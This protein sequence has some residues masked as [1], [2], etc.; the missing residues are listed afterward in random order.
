ME[1]KV[2][3]VLN[4]ELLSDIFR[5]IFEKIGY[6]SKTV[7]TP[8][9]AIDEINKSTYSIVVIGNI[10]GPIVKSKLADIIYDKA[11]GFKPHIV[12][13]KEPGDIVYNADH[14]TFV[15]KPAFHTELLNA[16][17]AIDENKKIT[18]V[19]HE[20]KESSEAIE[21]FVKNKEYKTYD[22]GEFFKQLKGNKKFEII[23]NNQKVVG[24]LMNNEFY[25]LS[26]DF[27]DPYYLLSLGKVEIAIEKFEL[28]EFLSLKLNK[29]VFKETLKDY[30]LKALDRIHN[31]DKIL[32]FFPA[33]DRIISIRA[34]KY[35][36]QQCKIA[37]ANFDIDWLESLSGSITIEDIMNKYKDD[38][39]KLKTMAAMY[40]LNMIEF[41]E[42][43]RVSNSKFD[44]QIKKS[45][46][47]K[48]MDK[49]RGL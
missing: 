32:S 27:D 45:F 46:L 18:D 31:V 17:S 19:L 37:N 2:L 10:K 41:T 21:E 16:I 24:F 47:E 30:I 4:D 20:V 7:Q 40:I 42:K 38:I 39:V 13:L 49:I 34:P 25:I 26:S 33:T 43:R 23:S 29:D 36:L 8:K 6:S 12:I 22:I 3:F 48:I 9:E 14:I 11:F 15:R 44:V 1:K 28:S 5:V 35:V